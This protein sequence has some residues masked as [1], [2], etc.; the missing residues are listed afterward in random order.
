[1]NMLFVEDDELLRQ[2]YTEYLLKHF[3]NVYEASNGTEGLEVF[4]EQNI[5]FILADVEMPKMNGLLMIKEIRKIDKQVPIVILTAY[6][7]REYL[8]NAIKLNL[9]DYLVKPVHY[10][11][12][13]EL[14]KTISLNLKG[15]K[16]SD[17]I[18]MVDDY[19]WNSKE[20]KLFSNTEEISLTKNERLFFKFFCNKS[21]KNFSIEDISTVV[22]PLEEIN[23]NKVRML[24]KRIRAKT[25]R[26]L[27]ENDYNLGFNFR[28]KNHTL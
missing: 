21:I 5:D 24:I 18:V 20:E 14:I 8:L 28:L 10:H 26:E 27:I 23:E 3:D 16:N 17:E 6:D 22:Y 9:Y 1:M 2:N 11:K 15:E 7:S 13:V 12:F 4:K 25:H 19:I